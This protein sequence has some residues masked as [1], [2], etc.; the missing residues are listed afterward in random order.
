LE[1]RQVNA[2]QE[3]QPARE[4]PAHAARHGGKAALFDTVF[5]GSRGVRAGW[6]A[7]VYV[8]TVLVL[9]AVGQL[10]ATSL[11]VSLAFNAKDMTPGPVF[12]H[13]GLQ[14]LA[15]LAATA[16]L[17]LVESRTVGEFG[18]PW[19]SAFRAQFWQGT[20]WGMAEI[21]LVVLLIAGLG[22]YAF[23]AMG[24]GG[25]VLI[26]MGGWLAVFAMVGLAEEFLFRGYLL[27]T[28]AEGMGF[29][30]ASV[31]LS[32]AFGAV[33]IGNPGESP[34]GLITVV[35]VGLFFCLT[36]RRTGSL[37]FAVGVH[38][39]HDFGQAF[40]YGVPNSGTL[41]RDP[42]FASSLYGPAWL[43]G[44]PAGPEGSVLELVVLA[45]MFLLFAAFYR[46][47]EPGSP[48]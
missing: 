17:G 6:R 27:K 15:A 37:W 11:G 8:S 32:V 31:F 23:G 13:E 21:S 28:L 4:R 30:P 36:V 10:A 39:A 25:R 46:R 26:S 38:A 35:L 16:A 47:E 44:G 24:D 42:L 7:G 19:R 20:L 14:F 18:L 43:T 48:S 12:L 41:I 22:G 5:I 3:T 2:P 29:W 1:H 34:L 45:L 33:H 40:V 9:V